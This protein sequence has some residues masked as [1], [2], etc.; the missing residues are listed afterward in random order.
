MSEASGMDLRTPIGALFVMLGV[1]LAGYG[2]V[3]SGDTALYARSTDI[4][5]NLVW[6]GVML[7][8]GAL[9]LWLARRAR[10]A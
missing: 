9:F 1:I 7:V 4:N 2:L 3:T 5:I 8:F 10:A 6:G